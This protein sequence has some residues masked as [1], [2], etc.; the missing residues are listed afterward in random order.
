MYEEND[1][2]YTPN[3]LAFLAGTPRERHGTW[4]YTCCYNDTEYSQEQLKKPRFAVGDLV[5][6]MRMGSSSFEKLWVVKAHV[7]WAESFIY[8]INRVDEE[9][10]TEM[11]GEV[12]SNILEDSL[13]G[14]SA[15]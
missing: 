2:V 10:R 11:P 13:Q 9:L 12:K 4:H 3:G 7:L 14:F 5:E 15:S 6:W 1:L 8:T